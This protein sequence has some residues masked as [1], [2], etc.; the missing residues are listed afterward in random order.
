MRKSIPHTLFSRLMAALAAALELLEL[1][2][3]SDR[4]YFLGDVVTMWLFRRPAN[5]TLK[6]DFRRQPIDRPYFNNTLPANLSVAAPEG[7][8]SHHGNSGVFC[9]RILYIH[10]TKKPLDISTAKKVAKGF[11]F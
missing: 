9:A 5:Q 2:P 3:G 10:I 6:L 1:S 8:L 11:S 7:G 4:R